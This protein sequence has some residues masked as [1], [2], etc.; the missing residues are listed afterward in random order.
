MTQEAVHKCLLKDDY[1]LYTCGSGGYGQ[2]GHG[3]FVSCSLPR[4]VTSFASMKVLLAACGLRHTLVLVGSEEDTFIYAFGSSKKGQLG[5]D[6]LGGDVPVKGHLETI[7]TSRPS[8]VRS[9]VGYKISSVHAGGEHSAALTDRGNLFVWGRGFDTGCNLPLPSKVSSQLI[10]AQVA[11]GWNHLLALTAGDGQVYTTGSR[12]RFGALNAFGAVTIEDHGGSGSVDALSEQKGSAAVSTQQSV[13]SVN[14]F[15]PLKGVSVRWIA[16]GSEHSAAVLSDG[17]IVTWGW[18][19][20][21]QLGLGTTTDQ[22]C[23][24]VVFSVPKMVNSLVYCGCG[25]SF[26]CQPCT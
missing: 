13:V 14:Q 16:A 7:Q 3:N 19:E 12:Q 25:F 26:L 1:S 20:H 10:F 6:F 8:L 2:L 24:N 17:S 9:L 15:G 11:L 4:R 18:G 21:G 22:S 23:P 5:L